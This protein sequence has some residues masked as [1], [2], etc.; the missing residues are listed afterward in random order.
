MKLTLNADSRVHARCS[1]LIAGWMV[2]VASLASF[3]PLSAQAQ[4]LPP[5]AVFTAIH[6]IPEKDDNAE[7]VELEDGVISTYWYGHEF[8]VAGR[9]FFTGF[10][11][12]TRD[13]EARKGEDI[14]A[15]D[16]Q[17]K[18]AQATFERTHPGK[19][20]A[21]SFY[22][23]ER[24]TGRF[25]GREKP[26]EVDTTRK[27][28]EFHTQ[29]NRMVLAVPTRTFENGITIDGYATFLFTLKKEFA[30]REWL[31][32]YTGA[33]Q[34]GEDNAAACDGGAVMPCASSKGELS[35]VPGQ[36]GLPQIQVKASGT[37]IEGPGK[38]RALGA[39]DAQTYVFDEKTRMYVS[40]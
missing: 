38:T 32:A 34:T 12:N 37:T 21:Y 40:K 35:F 23:V 18:I 3:A 15:P 2:A 8:D 7:S 14:A 27:A 22:A 24:K 33:I 39:A 19:T 30:L 6:N 25:G 9:H 10:V 36:G 1:T 11:W 16:V 20:P 4:K 29:D 13:A 31:W 28:L 17:V 5:G 26:P